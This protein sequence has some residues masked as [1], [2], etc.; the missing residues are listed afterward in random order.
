MVGSATEHQISDGGGVLITAAPLDRC[1]QVGNCPD[2]AT[3]T[4]LL[5]DAVGGVNV[6][7]PLATVLI[8]VTPGDR[9]NGECAEGH[10]GSGGELREL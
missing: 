5:A 10:R 6:A 2:H 8:Q 3:L 4:P 1:A 9:L 7:C